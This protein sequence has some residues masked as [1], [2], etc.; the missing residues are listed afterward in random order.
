MTLI[1]R[2]RSFINAFSC[3]GIS[4]IPESE[5]DTLVTLYN[6]TNGTNWLTTTNWL[7]TNTPCNW[8]GITCEAGRVSRIDLSQ[9]QLSGVIPTALG[10]L[11]ELQRLYLYDNQLSGSIPPELGNLT[12]IQCLY[13]YSNQ[14]SGSIPPELGNIIQLECL[15]LYDNQLSGSIPP[16]LS[17]LTNLQRLYLQNNQLSGNIPVQLGALT[18][19]QYLQLNDNQLSGNI[20][21]QLGNLTQLRYIYLYNNNLSGNIPSELGNLPL[22]QRLYLYNNQLS[23]SIPAA[24]GE[25]AE[26]QYLSLY[27][28]R[29]SGNIPP[30]LGKLTKLIRLSLNNNHLSGPIPPALGDLTTLTIA[31]LQN[32]RLSGSI[33]RELG[34]LAKLE[35][36]W[37]QSNQLSGLLPA[38]MM[39]LA[40]LAVL[41][42]RFNK[43][44]CE[45]PV[46]AFAEARE[47]N[48]RQSQTLAPTG[49]EVR[50]PTSTTVDLAWMPISYT[51]D[52]GGYEVGYAT[53]PAGPYVVHGITNRKTATA[54]TITGLCPGQTY[55][56]AVRTYTP[57][58]NQQQ[59]NLYSDFSQTLTATTLP[60]TTSLKFLAIYLLALD[61]NL[62]KE[63]DAILTEIKAATADPS[64]C[65]QKAA[66]VL[67]DQRGDHNTKAFFIQ[68]STTIT[69]TGLPDSATHQLSL[70]VDEYNMA[71]GAQLGAFIDWGRRQYPVAQT[72]LSFV[73]HGLPLAP[74]A[75]LLQVITP[76]TSLAAAV[77]ENIFLLPSK[78]RIYAHADRLTDAQSTSLISPYAL[79][80][81]LR[82]GTDNGQN[83]LTVLDIVHCFSGTIEEFYEVSSYTQ[84]LIGSPNYTYSSGRMLGRALL[85]VRP[86]QS[87][88]YM[89]EALIDAY[90]QTLKEADQ[91]SEPL[92]TV[93]HP[94]VLVALQSDK[95]GAIKTSVDQLA[96]ALTQGL[97]DGPAIRKQETI[98]KMSA[99]H[100]TSQKYDTTLCSGQ[101]ML[102][103][104]PNTSQDWALT[105]EDALS[106]LRDFASQLSAQFILSPTFVLT[107]TTVISQVDAAVIKTIKVSGTPWFAYDPTLQ[108]TFHDDIS[109]IGLYTDFQG[110]DLLGD[111]VTSLG[112]QAH[113]YNKGGEEYEDN[114]YPLAFLQGE[115]ATWADVLANFWRGDHKGIQTALC[116]VEFPKIRPSI[117][118]LP[119][120]QR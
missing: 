50:K 54:Y 44:N 80:E 33:P 41:H 55:Y 115:S 24:L 118:Y 92:T 87:A 78:E 113:W 112:W 103:S 43:L 29:L 62:S 16:E 53:E 102:Q 19:L 52:G 101:N 84:A 22:L 106:D 30:Q 39:D 109:G 117:V 18:T 82:I 58:H 108:W 48:W 70:A 77:D 85:A 28:N 10:G 105:S 34:N 40:S 36:L 90:D 67:A 17:R 51:D 63:R 37:L 74:S 59:N 98:A 69:I 110:I 93:E 49:V 111:G 2:L 32:N 81:A 107:A 42:L 46:C 6:S 100:Q 89:A 64:S 88:R 97:I 73:G 35:E 71:D 65:K 1:S 12:K 9:N 120:I 61:S 79:A 15:Y 38:T 4:G 94:R 119:I 96:A 14:L 116:T 86:G 3:V 68:G 104:G 76:S 99:A 13:L 31:A 23:G 27:D 66:L 72:I 8:Y 60:D 83:P 25:L 91:S 56:F 45:D 5:C 95:L 11:T 20:P 7:V 47:P 57:A 75:D 114:A 21:P 26:L